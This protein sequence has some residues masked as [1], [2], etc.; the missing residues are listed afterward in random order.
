MQ[1]ETSQKTKLTVLADRP[2]AIASSEH[3]ANLDVI[4]F[5]LS[6]IAQ[7]RPRLAVEL[8][9]LYQEAS[10]LDADAPPAAAEDFLAAESAMRRVSMR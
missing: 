7:R 10:Q 9:E 3:G 6:F 8:I 2:T 4:G 1:Y 5:N